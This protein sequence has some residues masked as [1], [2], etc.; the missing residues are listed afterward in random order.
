M[1]PERGGYTSRGPDV[2]DRVTGRG[3]HLVNRVKGAYWGRG[4]VN[5]VGDFLLPAS[6]KDI[7]DCQL[8]HWDKKVG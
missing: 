3:D 7:C 5:D 1:A 4:E 6:D 2:A 8:T